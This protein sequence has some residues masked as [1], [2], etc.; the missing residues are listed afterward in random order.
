MVPQCLRVQQV[1]DLVLV[2]YVGMKGEGRGSVGEAAPRTDVSRLEMVAALQTS[3]SAACPLPQ[4]FWA[5]SVVEEDQGLQDLSSRAVFPEG[6]VLLHEQI[7][8]HQLKEAEPG[9]LDVVGMEFVRGLKVV[10][11]AAKASKVSVVYLHD[12]FEMVEELAEGLFSRQL[13]FQCDQD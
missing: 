5:A 10:T 1:R 13:Y 12:S 6:A 11:L 2:N 8:Q 4:G 7:F 9:T 3:F